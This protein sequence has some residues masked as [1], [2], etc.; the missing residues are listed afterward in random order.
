MDECLLLGSHLGFQSQVPNLNR[1]MSAIYQDECF[2]PASDS[3]TSVPVQPTQRTP[4]NNR[5]LLSPYQTVIPEYLQATNNSN[6]SMGQHHAAMEDSSTPKTSLPKDALIEYYESKEGSNTPLSPAIHPT[7]QIRRCSATQTY[8]ATSDDPPVISSSIRSTLQQPFTF[9]DS[10]YSPN[11]EHSWAQIA[12]QSH[13]RRY[14]GQ[15]PPSLLS[16]VNPSS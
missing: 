15:Q 4:T 8:G 7:V 13:L 5:A 11:P 12:G 3:T 10:C 1:T 14:D 6:L 16:L 2:N 9:S